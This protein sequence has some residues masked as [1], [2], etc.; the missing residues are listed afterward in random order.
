MTDW[1]KKKL[2]VGDFFRKRNYILVGGSLLVLLFLF[3][4][5][6]NGGALT[7][8][9]LGQ[10]ATPVIAVWFAYLARK[11]LFDYLDM[12]A[13]YF[14][15]KESATGSAIVF[16]GVCLVFFGLLGLFG[17]SA[18]AQD[19]HTYIPTKATLYLP[20]VKAELSTLWVN[21]PK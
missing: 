3:F 13:L 6:P 2:P 1:I 18:K 4:T 9:F 11:A 5:D 19:V 15:A 14:K 7:V 17:N 8:T 10:L 16:V 21:H 12:D 20:T